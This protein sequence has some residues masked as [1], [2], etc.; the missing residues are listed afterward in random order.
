[1]FVRHVYRLTFSVGT[2]VGNSLRNLLNCIAFDLTQQNLSHYNKPWIHLST[3]N[4]L[5][6]VNLWLRG[7]WSWTSSYVY[8]WNES[9][10]S[11]DFYITTCVCCFGQVMPFQTLYVTLCHIHNHVLKE[12]KAV[13]RLDTESKTQTKIHVYSC[14]VRQMVQMTPIH[15]IWAGWVGQVQLCLSFLKQGISGVVCTAKS[16]EGI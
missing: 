13:C 6:L 10:Q 7:H 11:L 15:Q 8:G 9:L 12:S 4:Q 16:S 1:M 2:K 14:G 5:L 3:W